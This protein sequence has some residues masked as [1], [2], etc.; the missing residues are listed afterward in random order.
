MQALSPVGAKPGSQ[1]GQPRVVLTPRPHAYAAADGSTPAMQCMAPLMYTHQPSC[2]HP[3]PNQQPPMVYVHVCNHCHNPRQNPSTPRAR[4]GRPGRGDWALHPRS[5]VHTI[6]GGH[7]H[8]PSPPL[9]TPNHPPTHPP[10]ST[11]SVMCCCQAPAY[12][13]CQHTPQTGGSRQ[14]PCCHPTVTRLSPVLSHHPGEAHPLRP[15]HP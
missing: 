3:P 6:R 14:P 4:G 9:G 15:A 2:T 11:P 1:L 5:H 7:I 8:P 13:A 10:T 12:P